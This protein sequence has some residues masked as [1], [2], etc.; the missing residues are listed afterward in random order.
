[1][2]K[3]NAGQMRGVRAMRDPEGILLDS[4]TDETGLQYGYV[5]VYGE[6]SPAVY[7]GE[8]WAPITDKTDEEW[9]DGLQDLL[10]K[11]G[12]AITTASSTT[13]A[14]AELARIMNISI[15]APASAAASV[16]GSDPMDSVH[17]FGA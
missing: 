8:T 16:A 1:M 3:A 6:G 4:F 14:Y 15:E 5:I 12:V 17:N 11:Q 7:D 10:V 9:A 2:I 13:H